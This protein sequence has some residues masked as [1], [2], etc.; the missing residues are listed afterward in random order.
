MKPEKEVS[1]I[2]HKLE[3]IKKI[4]RIIDP[5][6]F[7]EELLQ[8]FISKT[9]MNISR[10]LAIDES[11]LNDLILKG[12]IVKEV[13]DKPLEEVIVDM[14]SLIYQDPEPKYLAILVSD[15]YEVRIYNSLRESGIAVVSPD[16][17]IEGPMA[18]YRFQ[19]LKVEGEINK[20]I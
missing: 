5:K 17:L 19:L 7:R 3:E 15:E 2:S 20:I 16:I 9:S 1:S 13:E 4:Q 6:Y 14:E 11:W 10:R 18:V 12:V 8:N